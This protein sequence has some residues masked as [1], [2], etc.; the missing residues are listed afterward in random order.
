MI[1]M[2]LRRDPQYKEACKALEEAIYKVARPDEAR[3]VY[4]ECIEDK[5]VPKMCGQYNDLDAGFILDLLRA[6]TA[7][8]EAYIARNL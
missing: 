4:Y 8:W 3:K 6:E 2:E 7:R 5:G 1:A